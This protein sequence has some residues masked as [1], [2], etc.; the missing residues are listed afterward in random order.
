VVSD[1]SGLL[2]SNWN[3][4][5]TG[6][7]L[8]WNRGST[9]GESCHVLG[10][11]A[12][13]ES[14]KSSRLK[15]RIETHCLIHLALLLNMGN[16]WQRSSLFDGNRLIWG[17]PICTVLADFWGF[18]CTILAWPFAESTNYVRNFLSFIFVFFTD[19]MARLT[20]FLPFG[21][22][23][24]FMLW[25]VIFL[26][27]SHGLDS[28]ADWILAYSDFCVPDILW[29]WT[30]NYAQVERPVVLHSFW[31]FVQ[32]ELEQSH[33]A[34]FAAIGAAHC[35]WCGFSSDNKSTVS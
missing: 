1:T 28:V 17:G 6:V 25:F 20:R 11:N 2:W 8:C 7:I 14:W 27:G 31:S 29:F 15:C 5:T 35:L 9:P 19:D 30:V 26:L 16:R 33:W 21:D 3:W 4:Q 32:P 22:E 23:C 12:R 13:L 18:A 10:S 34:M 24:F